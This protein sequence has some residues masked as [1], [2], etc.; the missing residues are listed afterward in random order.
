M[1]DIAIVLVE[2]KYAGNIGGV[3]RAMKN[4]G[5]KELI[6]VNPCKI[7][8]DAYKMAM[9]GKDILDNARIEKK[10]EEVIKNFDYVVGTSDVSTDSEKYYL[11]QAL[12]PSKFANW[13]KKVEGRICILFGREDYGLFN[14]ELERCDILLTIPGNK[15]YPVMNISHAAVVIFYELYKECANSYPLHR[16][17]LKKIEKNKLLDTFGLF[18]DKINYPSHKKKGTRIM[19][20]R[21]LGRAGISNWEFHRLMGVFSKGIKKLD[22]KYPKEKPIN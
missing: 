7:N 16:K 1:L 3:A 2:P 21:I 17:K 9:K 14:E 13:L 18:L 19:F 11:R 15:E 10:V 12:S 4:F 5:L 20:R 8:S 6:L 22:I